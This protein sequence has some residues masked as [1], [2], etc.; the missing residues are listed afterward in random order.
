MIPGTFRLCKPLSRSK[1][2][3]VEDNNN[4]AK[5]QIEILKNISKNIRKFCDTSM[6]NAAN[7]IKGKEIKYLLKMCLTGIEDIIINVA[8]I[9]EAKI[10]A[11]RSLNNAMN[12]TNTRIPIIF[13]R[14]SKL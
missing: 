6:V 1:K 12:T 2:G 3:V 10:R 14:G 11:I 9:I 5:T 7:N 8:T 4:N 13:A